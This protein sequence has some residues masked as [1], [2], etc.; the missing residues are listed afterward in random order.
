[1][2][3]NTVSES[4]Q[5]ERCLTSLNIGH[6]KHTYGHCMSREQPPTC[7]DCGEDT[8]LTIKHTLTE[9]PSPNNIKRQFLGSNIKTMKQLLND[10][11]TTHCDPLLNVLCYA[12]KIDIL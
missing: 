12:K 11:D 2:L 3:P 6:S 5:W 7:E 4:R 9:C 10:G 1:M 8:S